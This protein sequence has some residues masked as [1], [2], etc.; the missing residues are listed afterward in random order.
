M[1]EWREPMMHEKGVTMIGGITVKL[2]K[3]TSG[4]EG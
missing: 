4:H 2:S 3:D 1:S